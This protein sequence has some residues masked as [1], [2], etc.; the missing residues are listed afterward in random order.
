MCGNIAVSNLGCDGPAAFQMIHQW[1]AGT[2]DALRDV[3]RPCRPARATRLLRTA[4]SATARR[5]PGDMRCRVRTGSALI[6]S[7]TNQLHEA[8]DHQGHWGERVVFDA[9]HVRAAITSS[10]GVSAETTAARI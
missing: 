2:V 8:S 5:C 7:S 9:R 1:F 10:T 3:W 4:R 6:A